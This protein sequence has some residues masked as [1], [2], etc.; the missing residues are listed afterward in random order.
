MEQKEKYQA[1]LVFYAGSA[2][3]E[4][5]VWDEENEQLY[6]V[7]IPDEVIYRFDPT[8]TEIK[9]FKTDGPVGA[10]V[11][12]EDGMLIS[13][14]KNGIVLIDPDSGERTAWAHPITDDRMR[15][16]DGKLDPKGRFL[17]GTMGAEG[18]IEDAASLFSIEGDTSTELLSGLSIA[19]G[20]GWSKDGETFFHID[21]PTK[22]VKRYDY[23]LETGE[24]SNGKDCVE[25]SGDGNPDGMCVD[26]DGMLWVAEFSGNKVSKWNPENGEKVK[27]INMPVTNCTSCCIGGKDKNTLFITTAKEDGEELSGGLFKVRIR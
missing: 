14:E 27:E 11:L 8:T 3:L 21:T 4:G 1:E 6:F 16:N 13:A 23:N 15:Y 2:L 22:K 12:K 25:I 18:V 10:A 19:N 20:L 9:T 5:P 7:S 24:L 17:I 26:V